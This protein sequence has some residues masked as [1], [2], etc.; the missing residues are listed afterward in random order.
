VTDFAP[1]PKKQTAQEAFDAMPKT[2]PVVVQAKPAAEKAKGV[3]L[4]V[5]EPPANLRT[6]TIP[7]QQ[8]AIEPLYPTKCVTAFVGPGK[9]GK[10]TLLLRQLVYIAAGRQWEGQPTKHGPVW[11]FSAE[12]P[13]DRVWERAQSVI[14]G[15]NFNDIEF[16]AFRKN[17][18]LIDARGQGLYFIKPTP[19]GIAATGVASSIAER[20]GKNAVAVV[21]ETLSRVNSVGE[22]DNS[23]MAMIVT[24]CEYGAEATGAAWIIVHHVSKGAMRGGVVDATAHRG[25]QALADN[26]R[27][28]LYFGP[29][30]NDEEDLQL[31]HVHLSYGRKW[32]ATHWRRLGDGRLVQHVPPVRDSLVALTDWF[33][34][35]DSKPFSHRAAKDAY[36]E[37]SDGS[38]D[39]GER[40]LKEWVR[41][42]K[43]V[44]AGKRNGGALYI[45]ASHDQTALN[46][47]FE[48]A[49]DPF[50]I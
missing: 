13:V 6:A 8:Y 20:V 25:G 5:H 11:Y 42:G 29:I 23:A 41:D 12:D 45:P 46:K 15:E 9:Q 32:R 31:H 14:N 30:D 49:A 38:R 2:A 36:K 35:Q 22:N 7:P 39:A 40:L 16:A 43:L 18:R 21:V 17:F 33:V 19:G 47:A 48:G 28:Y 3:K 4:S 10:S 50:A 1:I 34:A 37:W 24:A 27:S 44:E 26:T